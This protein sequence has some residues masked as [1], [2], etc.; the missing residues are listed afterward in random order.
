[1]TLNRSAIILVGL[2]IL[3][4]SWFAGQCCLTTMH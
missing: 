1:L 3:G 4:V 2:P